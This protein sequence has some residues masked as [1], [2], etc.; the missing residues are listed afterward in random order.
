MIFIAAIAVDQITKFIII[1]R[2]ELVN[3]KMNPIKLIPDVFEIT[4]HTNTGM[5]WGMFQGSN[6]L[7]FCC[8]TIILLG[9]I[10]M[11]IK[12][13]PK[14]VIVM[15]SSALVIGG[16]VGN[17]IDR[18]NLG[19]VVDFLHLSLINF[20]IFNIADSCVSVGAVIFAVYIFI[21][22]RKNADQPESA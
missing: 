15:T 16:A 5:G 9:M 1:E 2:H 10:F 22:E 13:K 19:Y 14:S 12:L 18:V 8:V 4:Y 11:L 7:L 21:T 6:T 20:P 17:L 3:L